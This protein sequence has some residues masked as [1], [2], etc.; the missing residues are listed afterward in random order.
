MSQGTPPSAASS[1]NSCTY[2][3]D[4]LGAAIALPAIF[5]V[6]LDRLDQRHP[7]QRRRTRRQKIRQFGRLAV[8]PGRNE[9]VDPFGQLLP[10]ERSVDFHQ[11]ARR[12]GH[13]HRSHNVA[14]R[15]SSIRQPRRHA[16]RATKNH[17]DR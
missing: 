16:F 9:T 15:K 11:V 3:F 12:I 4:Q 1:G 13:G 17:Q 8:L 7:P 2:C 14:T 5:E 6:D 10:N